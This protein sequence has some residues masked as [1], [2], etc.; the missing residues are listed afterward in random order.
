MRTERRTR[1]GFTL[2]EVLVAAA[3]CILIMTLLTYAFQQGLDTLSVLKSTGELQERLRAAEIVIRDDLAADHLDSDFGARVS[4]QRIDLWNGNAANVQFWQPPRAGFFRIL[5]GSTSTSEGQDA[6]GLMSTRATD[7]ILHMSVKRS[8]TRADQVFRAAVPSSVYTGSPSLTSFGLLNMRTS[9]SE[10]VSPWAEVA[11]FLDTQNQTGTT[12]GSPGLPLF[13][14][15][16]RVR[17]MTTNTSNFN[18]NSNKAAFPSMS[19]SPTGSNPLNGPADVANPNNRLGGIASTRTVGGSLTQSDV[20]QK[21]TGL[22]L[23]E[24]ILLTNVIS[25]EVKATWT[26]SSSPTAFSSNTEFPFDDLPASSRNSSLNNTRV[27]DTWFQASSGTWQSPGTA[28]AV[29]QLIRVKTVQ[30]KVRVYDVK[31]KLARQ[32]TIVQNV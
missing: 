16:R 8:G 28:T 30:I 4:D 21:L 20:L 25:F 24:D 22:S 2:V 9:T 13:P 17:V 29:P 18:W 32:I 10:F 19:F 14:L 31:N 12:V 6:D 26:G 23:G 7:H 11:Y 3:L 27:F 5:Q 1:P 15:V